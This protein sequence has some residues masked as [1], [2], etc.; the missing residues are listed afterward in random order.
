M[1]YTA[2]E[3]RY[4]TIPYR[5]CGRSGLDLPAL[6]LGFWYNFGG[7]SIYEN[8]RTM[9]RTAFDAEIIHFDLANNYSP[10][11]LASKKPDELNEID[12]IVGKP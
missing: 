2:D 7:T 8:A 4:A 12:R 9:A 6:S 11:R 10:P 1:P 5:R 3:N